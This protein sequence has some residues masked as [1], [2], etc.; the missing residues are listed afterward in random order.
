MEDSYVLQ[1]LEPKFKEFHLCFCG[2]AQCNPLH[3][4]GPAVRPNY[5]I[6]YVLDGKGFYQVGDRK[7]ELSKG[8]GFLIEPE[9][10]TFY[11]ADEAEPWTYLW[12][13]FGGTRAGQLIHDIGLNSSQL[14]FQCSYGNDLKQ[15]VLS[16]LKHTRSTTD[17]IY[18]LQGKLYEFF[19][20]LSRDAALEPTQEAS[21]EN[22]Y[23]QEA[24]SFIRNN[25]ARGISVADISDHLNVNR[26]YLYTLF[27]DALDMSPKDFLTRFRVSRAKEQLTLTDFSIEHIA[28]S[29]GYHD[30][31][32]FSKA[33]KAQIGLT[34]SDYRK[35]NRTETQNKLIASQKE[36]EELMIKGKK[37][38]HEKSPK[39][40]K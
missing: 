1:L 38:I 17:N 22:N 20:V 13:G 18:F 34:P 10:L 4:F 40:A 14:I 9:T 7:Y 29:C 27:K 25:Y 31:L 33:F 28:H 30:A 26:S 21:Q 3:S 35:Q 12:I 19:S 5:I 8:Q 16:M 6:H 37:Y 24:I 23:V 39:Q 15:I 2:Y 11:Q 32:V 36:L